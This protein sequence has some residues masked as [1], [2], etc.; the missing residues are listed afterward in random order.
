VTQHVGREGMIIG[1]KTC[2]IGHE[3][4]TAPQWLRKQPR[5]RYYREA[6]CMLRVPERSPDTGSTLPLAVAAERWRL[7]YLDM[8]AHAFR[9]QD[10]NDRLRAE[11]DRRTA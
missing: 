1:S 3:S 4:G 10:E 2:T 9:L 11:L 6:T 7:G 8:A 5:E